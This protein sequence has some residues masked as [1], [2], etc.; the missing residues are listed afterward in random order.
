MDRARFKCWFTDIF[1]TKTISMGNSLEIML[2]HGSEEK[3]YIYI[4]V[5]ATKVDLDKVNLLMSQLLYQ[6]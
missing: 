3:K 2:K 4:V 6:Q 1:D 5:G